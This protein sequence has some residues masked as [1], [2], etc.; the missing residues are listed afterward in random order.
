MSATSPGS[1]ATGVSVDAVITA[2]FNEAMDA[3]SI[4]P[5]TFMV[6]DGSGTIGGTVSYSG[7]KSRID[8]ICLFII[9]KL[10]DTIF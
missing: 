4:T 3:G 2:T 9:H 1:G 7:T 10:M 8:V 6:S 5:S